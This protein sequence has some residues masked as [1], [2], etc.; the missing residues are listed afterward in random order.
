M[1]AMYRLRSGME[2]VLFRY[3]AAWTI[4]WATRS[5][6]E[7]SFYSLLQRGEHEKAKN[8]GKEKST[9]LIAYFTAIQQCP[10]A[11]HIHYVDFP[12]YFR[13]Y[14]AVRL[15]KQR[16]KHK[17]C[18][19]LTPQY[20]FSE[21][22]ERVVRSMYNIIPHEGEGYFLRTLLQHKWGAISFVN[23]RF[24]ESVQYPTFRNTCCVLDLLSDDAEWLKCMQ[25][26]FSSN[27]D[28]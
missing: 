18:S 28:R 13:W 16:S 7:W 10:N 22:Q 9:K 11:C 27:V 21:V 26:A 14:K 4:R 15:W 3:S 20:D 24:H 12:K 19:T 8:V 5:S 2:A 17:L 1:R 25:G 6:F 23:M